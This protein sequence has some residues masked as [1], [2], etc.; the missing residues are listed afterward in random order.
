MAGSA[1]S[2]DLEWIEKYRPT[3]LEGLAGQNRAVLE[4]RKWASAWHGGGA[5]KKKGLIL[6]GEPGTGKTTAALALANEMGWEPIELNA[7]DSRNIDSIRRLVTRGSQSMDITDPGGFKGGPGSRMKLFILDEADNLHERSAR[8]GESDVGDTGG[9]RAILELLKMTR[10]PVVLIVNDLYGL[11]KG[12]GGPIQFI[13]ERV[14]FRRLAVPSIVNRLRE[15][16]AC[17]GISFEEKVLE[18]IASRSE[19]DLRSAVGDLQMVCSGRSRVTT[20]DLSVLGV[21]DTRESIFKVIERVFASGDIMASKAALMN[22]DNAPDMMLLWLAENIHSEMS[23]PEDLARGMDH[24]SRA[25]VFLGRVRRRQNYRLWT[26]ANDMMASV[27]SARRHPKKGYSP[28]RFPS[29]LKKMSRTKDT[30]SLLG[31]LSSILGGYTHA[32]VRAIREDPIYRIGQLVRNDHEFASHLAWKLDLN[33]EHL[34]LMGGSG[35]GEPQIRSILKKAQKL[36]EEASEPVP[37]DEDVGLLL[38]SETEEGFE[39]EPK[40]VEDEGAT[41]EDVEETS[42]QST[43]FDF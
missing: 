26:Y 5:P 27:S 25:D 8:V 9:K 31:E 30:R 21:R 38:Y 15:I 12:S 42:S 10:Q 13:C 7:S 1:T 2:K 11:T 37:I 36:R 23:H 22:S 3:R 6:E 24:L 17:E 14:R 20:S 34:K 18:E 35:L 16:M 28:Y 4:M 41:A 32:S 33:K 29:Y 19:G 40:V 39:G 43:L